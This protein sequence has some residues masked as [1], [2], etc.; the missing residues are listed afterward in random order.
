MNEIE[1]ELKEVK[2]HQIMTKD[3]IAASPSNKF[4]QA[5]QFFCEKNINHLPVCENGE[6]LGIISNKDMMRHVYKHLVVDK[7]TDITALDSELKLTDVMTSKPFSVTADT[8][9]LAVKEIFGRAPFNCLPVTHEG[10]LVGIVTPKDL[11]Q[12]RIIHI[13]GSQYGGY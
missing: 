8:T 1:D 10:K 4:S 6:L 3:I 12:M 9:V 7:K 11:M 5:F 13:D 2:I